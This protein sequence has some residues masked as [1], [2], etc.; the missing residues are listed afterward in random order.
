MQRSRRQ[1]IS[2]LTSERIFSNENDKER[3][4]TNGVLLW[5]DDEIEQLKAHL[6]FLEK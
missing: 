4:M 6:L 3:G 2:T 1:M 5:V